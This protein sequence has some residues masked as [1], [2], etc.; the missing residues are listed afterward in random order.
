MFACTQ[1]NVFLKEME[2]SLVPH[3]S[4]EKASNDVYYTHALIKGRSKPDKKLM[5]MVVDSRDR[6]KTLFPNPNSYEVNLI[7]D[8][9]HVSS[10]QL[11][12]YDFPFSSYLISTNNNKLHFCVAGKEVVAIVD[13]G[14]Y[15]SG[16]DLAS[17]LEKAMNEAVG[18]DMFGVA[19]ISRTDNFEITSTRS[20]SLRFCGEQV[21]HPFNNNYDVAY[22]RG[23]IGRVLGFGVKNYE[24][25][26][27]GISSPYKNA[28][29]SEFRK[30]FNAGDT[31]V[32]NI[33][34]FNLNKSSANAVNESFL[35]LTRNMAFGMCDDTFTVKHFFPAL[36][37]L[38]KIK[39]R[40]TDYDGNL[41]DFQNQDHRMEF[42]LEANIKNSN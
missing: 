18:N 35:V 7:D 36:A 22:P 3:H 26:V 1:K 20:F 19:Y 39:V 33:E 27:L 30:N 37:R 6:C 17:V 28:I 23:S 40:V 16:A 32:V 10:I 11:R 41:Y 4:C 29:K 13:V 9:P 34:V 15:E 8:I 25:T 12:A 38:A 42:I 21:R 14:D 5:R 2:H 31:V 24:S